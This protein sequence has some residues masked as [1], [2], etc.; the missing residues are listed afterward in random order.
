MCGRPLGARG[1]LRILTGGSIAS[2]CAACRRGTM[3]AGP[4]GIRDPAPN[5]FAASKA[6]TL[7]GFSGSSVR[8]IVISFSS[9]IPASTRAYGDDRQT[10]ASA[11][12][13]IVT[14]AVW[15]IP[16]RNHV[17]S[18]LAARP[19][20]ARRDRVQ[21]SLARPR[22]AHCPVGCPATRPASRHTRPA[23]PRP[24][25][26]YRSTVGHARGA[27]ACLT[28]GAGHALFIDQWTGHGSTPNRYVTFE[29][30]VAR[31]RG[32]IGHFARQGRSRHQRDG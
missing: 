11:T 4:D 30:R 5:N 8:P 7:I 6:G 25:R 28:L 21:Q 20:E 19:P 27:I 12:R 15:A 13:V 32:A 9:F 24:R 26:W 18:P 16:L 31:E 29:P 2:M 14:H 1:S 17:R 23:A 3:S 22:R 10:P